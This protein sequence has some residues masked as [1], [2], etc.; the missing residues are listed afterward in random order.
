MAVFQSLGELGAHLAATGMK[1]MDP[2][3]PLWDA[4]AGGGDFG[5][6]WSDQ[7]SVR[8]VVEFIARNIASIPLH[9]Y[10]RVDDGDRQRVR[11][12]PLART[13]ARPSRAPGKTPYRFWES[14]LIDGLIFDR[15]C[16][17]KTR[18]QD[19]PAALDLVRI[20]A[21][22]VRFEPDALDRI[23]KVLI[24]SADGKVTEH[25][26]AKFIIDVGYS[27]RGASGTSPMQTLRH[28]LAEAAEAVEYRRSVWKNGARF[29]LVLERDD[30]FSSIDAYN[31]FV[32][33]WAAFTRGGGKEGGT[34]I[35]EDGM[36][37]RAIEG[38][39]PKDTDDLEGR[40]L[41][42]I[43]VTSAYHIAPELVG[44]REGTYSNVDAFRQMLYRDNLGPYIEAWVQALSAGLTPEL[45]GGTDLYIEP[46]MDAKLRGSFLEQAQIAQ[47]LVG[48]PSMTRNEY[49]GRQ[50]MPSIE[51]GDDLVVPLNVL[52]GG[53]ASP[54]DSGTQNENAS[55][56]PERKALTVKRLK[57]RAPE[58]HEAKYREV[59]EKFFDRQSRVV[60]SRLGVKAAP[61]WWDEDR[62]DKELADDLLRLSVQTSQTAARSTLE[63]AGL[64]E[65]DVDRTLAFLKE[66]AERS[67]KNINEFTRDQITEAL[68]DADDPGEAVSHVFDIAKDSRT[69]EIA[70]TAVT[71]A[72]GFGAMEAGR[73]NSS[74]ATK[75]WSVTSSN[76][77]ASHA[78]MNGE[79]VG[80][81]DVF[82]N[83]LRWPGG[84]GDPA[85]VAGCQCALDIN[86]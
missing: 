72:S 13:L 34:P 82:S 14:V 22:R 79:T 59:L 40:R 86:F 11:D 39:K 60:Q 33:S 42:D 27:E 67:S 81:D 65:Y 2:G 74:K 41:T 64:S 20:P 18:A 69:A 4:T 36:K 3:I 10:D 7:P 29:P 78:A 70:T 44:A 31:R 68:K 73:Q 24:Y 84:I 54:R 71:F 61:D 48:A 85:E 37:A 55:P 38:F 19:D 51:G 9:V 75:T 26:P 77:R 30:A 32:A 47:S 52:I 83:N 46:H 62:W 57:S 17:M 12:H 23:V 53:Q 8:K 80:I 6:V 25:D 5:P 35:L 76:P 56:T 63:A 15:W 45:A 66:A 50:N 28:I 21:R 1:V 16:L 43:E 58:T 49:R